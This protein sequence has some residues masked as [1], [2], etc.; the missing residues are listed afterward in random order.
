MK[1][2]DD[3]RAK[4]RLWAER[5]VVL[6]LPAGPPLPRFSSRR[7]SSHAEMNRWK[8]ELLLELAGVT[9]QTNDTPS[10]AVRPTAER[11]AS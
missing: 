9:T 11:N 1:I 5:P 3:Y 6:P 2:S 4:W 10:A 7:F 8:R